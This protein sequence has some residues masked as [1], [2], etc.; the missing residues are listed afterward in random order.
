MKPEF[1]KT[2]E[3]IKATVKEPIPRVRFS[4]DIRD[5]LV[6]YSDRLDYFEAMTILLEYHPFLPFDEKLSLGDTLDYRRA[7]TYEIIIR[8]LGHCRSFIANSNILNHIGTA[9]A[10][11]C[12]LE[13]YAL[14]VYLKNNNCKN[15]TKC[16]YKL[17]HGSIF[18]SGEWYELEQEWKEK[19]DEHLPENFKDFLK[20]FLKTPHISEYL[21]S[22]KVSDKGFDYMYAI[23]STF[24]HPTFGRPRDQ[25]IQDIGQKS[26][27]IALEDSTYYLTAQKQPSPTNSLK[28]DISVAGFCL[29]FTWPEIME[30]DPLFDKEYGIFK[31]TDER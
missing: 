28:R 21:K 10:L 13:L 31:D 3:K 1:R 8:L 26:S 25:F 9:V 14:L 18:S 27:V 12:M 20:S 4:A 29:E 15:D 5:K 6:D 19:H 11:R 16:L 24:V 2:I 22:I 17:L 30:L 7:L 23:Y